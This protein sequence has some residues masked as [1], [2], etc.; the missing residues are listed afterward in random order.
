[1]PPEPATLHLFL[2]NPMSITLTDTYKET[3]A[4]STVMIVNELVE[5]GYELE[6]VLE[7][8]DYFGEEFSE[9]VESIID[10]VNDT[11]AGKSD[12]YDFIQEH[13][14][15]NLEHFAEYW[16]LLDVHYQ[17]PIDAF[18]RL[19]DVNQLDNFDDY[20]YGEFCDVREFVEHLLELEGTEIPSWVEV[21]YDATWECS[22][23]HDYDEENG[24]YFRKC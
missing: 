12:V 7:F 15:N 5:N 6:E 24:Y 18:I 21:D 2:R 11:A 17:G 23:R 9:V 3:L 16:R 8:V 13:G 14:I 22:L 20:Y 4:P 1:M 19:Y 10:M